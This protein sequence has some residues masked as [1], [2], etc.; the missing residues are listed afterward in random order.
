MEKTVINVEGMM[1]MHCAKHVEDACLKV[2]GVKT[3]K[4]DLDKKNVTLE[5]DNIDINK[6][7]ENINQAGYK[8]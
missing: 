7:K 5:G 3:A 4:V 2:E 6:V 1:C 8:A